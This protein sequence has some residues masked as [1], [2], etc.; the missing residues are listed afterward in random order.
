LIAPSQP[1]LQVVHALVAGESPPGE[2][3]LALRDDAAYVH[4]RDGSVAIV[5][6]PSKR[7]QELE[8]AI[9]EQ[10]AADRHTHLKLVI[11]GGEADMR[12][13]LGR[14]QPG[15]LSRRMVQTYHLGADGTV[16]GGRKSSLDTPVGRAL[17]A[18]VA[19]N[20]VGAIGFAD[21]AALV[22]KISAEEHAEARRAYEFVQR[23]RGR[24]PVLTR[25]LLV[26]LAIVFGLELLWGGS[27]YVPTLVRM[28][29]NTDASLGPEPW[30]LLAS[31]C[32]HAGEAHFIING[33]VLLI[34]GGELERILGWARLSILLVASGLVGSLA[35]ALLSDAALSVGASGAIWGVLGAAGAIAWRPRGLLPPAIVRRMRQ[36]AG[37]NL[38]INLAASFLP[39]VDLWAHL[40]GGVAGAA[41]VLGG[42]LT[43]G[44]APLHEQDAK[45]AADSSLL[46]GVAIACVVALGVSSVTAIVVGRPWMIVQAPV[47]I[48]REVGGFTIEVPESLGEPEAFDVELGQGIVLGDPLVDPLTIVVHTRAREADD[49]FEFPTDP[50]QGTAVAPRR[51]IEDAAVPT[52]EDRWVYPNG[53][54]QV[55]RYAF[56]PEASVTIDVAMLPE[57]PAPWL[58]AAQHTMSS[59]GGR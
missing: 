18:I 57:A 44:L 8:Q 59:I 4:M 38:V 11:V 21:L 56:F 24:R 15:L 41:L 54:E 53:F 31:V 50:D 32:L 43:R 52:Y 33:F 49:P 40:G 1:F 7:G 5:I 25:A 48:E 30:R 35:S 10:L 2:V 28:G 26:G 42:W 39:Q 47:M 13:V 6:N 20:D 36:A 37:I 3:L 58:E 27:D 14:V 23:F 16:W 22:P 17:Q 34:L 12:D 29:A 46:R 19:G 55:S 51:Q 45:P 9:R